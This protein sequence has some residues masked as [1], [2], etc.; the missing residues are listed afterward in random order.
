MKLTC[1]VRDPLTW[2]DG[3]NLSDPCWDLFVYNSILNEPRYLSRALKCI[4]AALSKDDSTLTEDDSTDDSTL[5]KDDLFTK[6]FQELDRTLPTVEDD[7]LKASDCV[8]GTIDMVKNDRSSRL[9]N[10]QVYNYMSV[11]EAGSSHR[12]N[13]NMEYL[14]ILASIFLPLS[15]FTVRDHSKIF[16]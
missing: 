5:T 15:L 13:S 8:K 12:T 9:T 10:S 11:K 4:K 16:D 1:Q 7:V 2:L 6:Y 14:A 3:L